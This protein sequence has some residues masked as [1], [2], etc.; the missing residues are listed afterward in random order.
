MLE[1]AVVV[2]GSTSPFS[3]SF[4][5]SFSSRKLESLVPESILLAS[6]AAG[7]SLSSLLFVVAA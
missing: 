3:G 7:S 1:L 4:S 2:V 6:V 5:G